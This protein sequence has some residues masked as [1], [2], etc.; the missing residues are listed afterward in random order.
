MRTVEIGRGGTRALAYSPDGTLYAATGAGRVLAV[1]AAGASRELFR[2]PARQGPLVAIYARPD[3]D[4]LHGVIEPFDVSFRVWD[5]KQDRLVYPADRA[6]DPA[7]EFTTV[8]LHSNLL[9]LLTLAG[10]ELPRDRQFA[11]LTRDAAR[12]NGSADCSRLVVATARGTVV[13]WDAA[14]SR[15]MSTVKL[16]GRAVPQSLAVSR[17]GVVAL[18]LA[19]ELRFYDAE[20]GT[21]TGSSLTAKAVTLL[22]L[23]AVGE[24]CL[25]GDGGPGVTVWRGGKP[26]GRFDFGVGKVRSMAVA[27]DGLTAA[28]GGTARLVAVVDLEA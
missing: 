12:L 28:I 6:I 15:L 16:A 13:V 23:S 9:R 5:S 11:Q 24:T 8:D 27:P 3:G 26:A 14:Q 17:T 7:G 4:L 20:T 25:S 10:F 22:A 21:L 1:D 18:G 19:E 2:V